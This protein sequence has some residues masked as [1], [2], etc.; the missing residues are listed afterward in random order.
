[1][2]IK[3]C[4]QNAS[5]LELAGVVSHLKAGECLAGHENASGYPARCP[6]DTLARS[7]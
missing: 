3:D 7:L 1:M 4:H 6:S 2:Q 5:E